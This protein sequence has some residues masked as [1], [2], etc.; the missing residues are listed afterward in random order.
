M[1]FA[2]SSGKKLSYMRTLVGVIVLFKRLRRNWDGQQKVGILIPPSV[3]GALTNL[4]GILMGKTVVNLNYTLSEE[5]IRSCV[6]QCD[7]KCVISSEK[8][9]R[10]LKLDP[11]VPMLALEDIAKDPSFME[12]MSATFLAYLC[13]RGI[14]LKKLAQGNPPSLDDI[15][16]IIFSSGSTGEPKGAMLSHYNIV[17]NMMQLNQAYDFKR[18]DRFLGVLPFF[19]SLGFTATLIGPA[20]IGVGA[21]YHPLPTD[22][23]SI[24]KLIPHYKLTLLLATPTFLQLY[25]RGI[26]PEQMQS[27]NLVV[28]GAEKLPQRLAIAFEEKF[29]LQPFEA[30]GC[31]ECS[32]GVAVNT[33]S[34]ITDDLSQSGN[35]P[36]TIGRALPGMSIKIVDPETEEPCDFNESGLM[37]VRGPNIMQ[38]Y[39]GKERLTA[40]VLVDG[41]YNTGDIASVDEE[42]FITITDRL[43]RFSKIGGEMVP[44]IKIEELLHTIAELTEQTFAVTGLPD[45]KKGER[46]VVLYTLEKENLKKITDQLGTSDIP[47]LWK[48][49]TD[50][51]FKVDELPYLGTGK[52]DLK[53]IKTM[54]LEIADE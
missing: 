22:T 1:A 41:W 7:I 12:K 49:K 4:A 48:P 14:L 38:G 23:R 26:K 19:H 33:P 9:I 3:G 2:D 37:W 21:A 11:G 42:G 40:E 20:V 5:G 18:D 15:A 39:L 46:L 25:L 30:Y 47:N 32:P 27:I 44:H 45:E 50:Q 36:G 43:S 51:F 28:V 31:T 34:L 35:R 8:V 16:T 17:S 13:P 54:A 24:G 6:Q 10:K 29:G 53:A 52:L